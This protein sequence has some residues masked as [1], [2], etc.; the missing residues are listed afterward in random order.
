[1]GGG[2]LRI[3]L[4]AA[5]CCLM[6]GGELCLSEKSCRRFRNFSCVC[7]IFETIEIN[8]SLEALLLRWLYVLPSR[9]NTLLL[10]SGLKLLEETA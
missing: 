9:D 7:H 3:L 1:M 4:V 8:G 6:I 10:V 5:L 2:V